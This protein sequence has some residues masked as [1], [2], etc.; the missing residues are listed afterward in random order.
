MDKICNDVGVKIVLAL[1]LV[2]VGRML[3]EIGLQLVNGTST[4]FKIE[5]INCSL[6]SHPELAISSLCESPA[7]AG[8]IGF[9]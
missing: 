9:R 5:L 7:G 2:L 3:V 8:T 1:D 4:N 6:V